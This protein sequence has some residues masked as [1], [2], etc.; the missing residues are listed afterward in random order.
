MSRRNAVGLFGSKINPRDFRCCS[1]GSTLWNYFFF[2]LEVLTEQEL[3][4]RSVLFTYQ[5]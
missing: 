4:I 2:A 5:P 1:R 3:Q